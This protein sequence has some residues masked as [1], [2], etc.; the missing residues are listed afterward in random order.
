M[1]VLALG[2]VSISN[3]VLKKI[4]FNTFAV[5]IKGLRRCDILHFTQLSA[6]LRMCKKLKHLLAFIKGVILPCH[7]PP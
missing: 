4:C 5:N 2:T 6:Q 7:S 3:N 1:H